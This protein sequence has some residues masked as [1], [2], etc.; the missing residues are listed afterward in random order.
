[1]RT[2]KI[3]YSNGKTIIVNAKNS[4]DV[5]KKYDLTNKENINTKIEEV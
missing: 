2:F 3:K 1:M 4:L 5:I